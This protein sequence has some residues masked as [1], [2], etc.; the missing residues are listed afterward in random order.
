MKLKTL[1]LPVMAITMAVIMFACKK[2]NNVDNSNTSD[3]DLQTQS[4][5]QTR[6]SNETDDVT[7]DVNTMLVAQTTVTGSGFT[8]VAHNGV[9][10]TGAYAVAS[11]ICDASVMVDT[12][13]STR[14]VTITYNGKNC[15][16]TRTRTGVVVISIPTGVRWSDKGA[17]I[18]VSIQNLK[19]TRLAD[20]KSITLNGTH[21]YTNVS[22]GSLINLANLTSITH[23]VT[24]DDMTVTF[25]DGSKRSWHVARQRMYTYSNGIVVTESGTHTEGSTSGITEWGSNR[26]GNSFETVISTP[27]VV[28]QSCSF[29][30]TSGV[31]SV[32]RPAVT[33]TLT[34][35]LDSGGNPVSGDCPLVYYFK[36]SWTGA[37]GKV[38]TFILPY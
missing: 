24:S 15:D 30:I 38:Y 13:S 33:V 2:S 18:T 9:Q 5:D 16:L 8:P 1:Y 6:V 22:G 26:F 11:L 7:N 29:R 32:I 12:S 14:T 25:D 36:L 23:T 17:V 21:T 28:K 34:L 31:I 3:A 35:G 10:T 19:I 37:A 20:S 4:D 27:I